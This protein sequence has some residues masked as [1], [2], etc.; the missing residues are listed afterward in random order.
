MW[1]CLPGILQRR[2]PWSRC[3]RWR[4]RAS[5]EAAEGSCYL[6]SSRQIWPS[7]IL[8]SK[9]VSECWT[10]FYIPVPW[11]LWDDPSWQI[12]LEGIKKSTVVITVKE[13]CVIFCSLHPLKANG[14]LCIMPGM[15]YSE[16]WKKYWN[17]R[18][19]VQVLYFMHR[20]LL[21]TVSR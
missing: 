20:I 4:P 19:N 18:Q 6:S 9:C 10:N 14:Y 2:A 16:L 15:Q 1:F 17:T 12:H 7:S 8:F 21:Y 3:I 11:Q 5:G 13:V